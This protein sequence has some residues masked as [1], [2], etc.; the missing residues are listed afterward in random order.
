M[1]LFNIIK[2]LNAVLPREV[3]TLQIFFFILKD[4]VEF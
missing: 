4:A 2:Y 3:K 1:I